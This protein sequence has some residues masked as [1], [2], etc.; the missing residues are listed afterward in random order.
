MSGRRYF[1]K[2]FHTLWLVTS[3]A[4]LAACVPTVQQ[5]GPVIDVA[6]ITADEIVTPDGARLPLRSWLPENRPPRA[7][8]LALHG[9]NDYGEAFAEPAARLT[10]RGIATF[11]Y[12]QRGFGATQSAGIWPGTNTMVADMRTAAA[13][14]RA[15]YPASP[16]YLLGESMGAAVL[17]AAAREGALPADGAVLTAPAVRARETMNPVYRTALWLGAHLFPAFE[18]TGEGLKIAAT[19]NIEAVRRLRDDPLVIKRTRVDAVWGLVNL[20][21]AALEGAPHLRQPSLIVYGA[22]DEVVPKGPTVELVARLRPDIPIAVYHTGWHMV[23]RDLKADVV[24]TDIVAWLDD[25]RRETLPSGAI[26]SGTEFFDRTASERV[27]EDPRPREGLSAAQAAKNTRE[28]AHAG[29]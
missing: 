16:F 21:D 15:R 2:R 12:D 29:P 1:A 18:V 9:F 14:L 17:L 8:I 5:V 19:D 25:P 6:R 3:L 28:R 22:N 24:L 11:A 23:L 4:A 10:E 20:M 27:T 7:V 13:L 26:R